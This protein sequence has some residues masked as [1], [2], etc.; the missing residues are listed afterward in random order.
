VPTDDIALQFGPY[1]LHPVQGLTRGDRE[2][3]VTPKSLAVLYMLA[4]RSGEIVTKRELF[5]TAW[6]GRSVTDAA[7]S[8]CIRELR[9][10]L[11]D[12]ARKPSYLETVHRRGFRF[13]TPCGEISEGEAAPRPV[14][15]RH[16]RE[17]DAL[18]E[19]LD[20]ARRG[21]ARLVAVNGAEGSGRSTL[22]DV[23]A[24]RAAD[25]AAWQVGRGAC[26]ELT[27]RGD[28]Y[29]PLLE[30]LT[31]LC[32]QSGGAQIVSQLRLH[33]P[34]WLA[35]LTSVLQ[36]GDLAAQRLIT[37][38]VTTARLH[39]ELDAALTAIAK[40]RPLLLILEDLQWSDDGTLEWLAGFE[41]P[42]AAP[43]LVLVTQ[44]ADA[45]F[46]GGDTLALVSNDGGDTGGQ[47]DRLTERE[48]QILEAAG[49]IGIRF[50]EAEVARVL[51]LPRDTVADSLAGLVAAGELVV[52]TGNGRRTDE[53]GG[54]RYRFSSGSLRSQLL[55]R[56]PVPRSRRLHRRVARSLESALGESSSD[57][58]PEL[59]VRYERAYDV[60]RAVRSYH[61]AAVLCRRRGVHR[62]AQTHLRRA[63]A[64]LPG[65]ADTVERN[66][67]DALLHVAAGGELT[68][69][70]GL[71]NA[72]ADDYYARALDLVENM[73]AS[74]SSFTILF[75]IWVFY[76]HRGPVAK[77][78][79][80]ARRLS[81]IARAVDD[82]TLELNARHAF[83][84]TA[85][86][87]GDVRNMLRYTEQGMALCGSGLDGATAI[88]NGCTLH[89]AHV[90][91]HNAAVCAGF[92]GAWAKALA[93][94][95]QDARRSIDTTIAHARDFRHP[96]SLA[97]ALVQSAGALTACGD[98]VNVRRYASEGAAIAREHGFAVLQAWGSIY[99]GW[100]AARMGDVREGLDMMYDGLA[101][102]RG[103]ELWLFRPHQLALA[104]DVELEN[105]MYDAAARSLD[106][107][108]STANSA[109]DRLAA[110]EL[111]RLRGEHAIAVA[112]APEDLAVAER[113]LRTGLD[114]ATA[115]GAA[116]VRARAARSLERFGG[117]A[118]R[119]KKDTSG[120]LSDVTVLG[121]WR[122]DRDA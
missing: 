26:D 70:K 46:D 25:N 91:N 108:F 29:R 44:T 76:F 32:L 67:W 37:S 74:R 81:E 35:E 56:L 1:R 50:S 116:Y 54:R 13:I 92:C 101:A 110:A 117:V 19:Y 87:L 55:G 106:E 45:R 14:D 41:L 122:G 111:H 88:I 99:E 10:A 113:D 24:A 118:G 68:M 42:D 62:T 82:P 109:G 59:A 105:R 96:F 78:H 18:G 97:M 93:G 120:Q 57:R 63:L 58:S 11:G 53:T 17:L 22:V 86:I 48:R 64:I 51:D 84:G 15:V 121:E 90:S 27:G 6:S 21:S 77:A 40:G 85:L 80:I 52:D 28:P 89:D 104:A 94:R 34:T 83:W 43:I 47:V 3:H 61:E 60:A 9:Q 65:I 8:S 39:R 36:P 30:A 73:Q 23:F 107:A 95:R 20:R 49:I 4:R 79:D 5:D 75:Q 66:T 12:D 112:R 69:E 38:G 115:T 16:A 103:T 7:L 71:G 33:A 31:A 114:I 100:A 98:A 72:E 119:R 2:I 102:F